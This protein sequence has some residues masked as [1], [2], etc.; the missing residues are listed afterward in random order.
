MPKACCSHD[1]PT[2]MVMFGAFRA[3]CATPHPHPATQ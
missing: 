3:A 1:T 2:R